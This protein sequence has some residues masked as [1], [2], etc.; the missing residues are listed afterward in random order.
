MAER[1]LRVTILGDSKGAQQALRQ[2]DQAGSQVEGR[3]SQ[4]G[5][6]LQD[7]GKKTAMVGAGLTA[8]L[9]LP[10]V[11]F[12][13]KAF[14]EAQEA[15]KVGAQTAA[16]IK[17]TGGAANV[18]ASQ[19]DKL[20]SSLSRKSGIDDEVIASGQNVLLT[21]TKVRNEAGKGNDVFN[22]G[23]KAALDLSVALKT[24]LQSATI[25]VGKALN[26]PVKGLT[27]LRKS[28]VQFTEQQENQ[29]KTMVAAGDQLGAQKMILAELNTQFAGSAEAQAT[30]AD[31]MKVAF[32]NMAEQIGKILTPVIE[33]LTGPLEKLS[34][35]FENLGARGQTIAV[36]GA[37][38]LAALGPLVTVV[39]A[40]ATVLGVVLSPIG[41]IVA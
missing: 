38:V 5:A 18:S 31:K 28:G 27:A 25:L 12:G 7:F 26:D 30:S 3:F 39:G 9:T 21:F 15:Q 8:G 4:T 11:A 23:T 10:L 22:Q 29:I 2:L 19:V 41:L 17:S 36:V 40:L 32:G 24:D 1:E 13:K 20:A 16:V 6:K 37:V 33:R 35:A 14:D 34:G